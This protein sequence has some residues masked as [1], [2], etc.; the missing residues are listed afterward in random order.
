LRPAQAANVAPF[1]AQ[2]D[3]D[4]QLRA[5]V[6]A[7]DP[8]RV[9]TLLRAGAALERRDERGRTPLMLAVIE[10]RGDVVRMLLAAGA[11]ANALDQDGLSPLER[12]RE[13]QRS[14]LERLLEASGGR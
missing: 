8:D 9:A 4:A 11:D 13:A 2:L 6:R 1:A 7:G 5:A 3:T 14:D 10:G 12:A